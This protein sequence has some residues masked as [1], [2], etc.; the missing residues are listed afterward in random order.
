MNRTRVEADKKSGYPMTD[1][2]DKQ[3]TDFYEVV[4][5]EMG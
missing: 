3:I 4:E 1:N 2:D 5:V